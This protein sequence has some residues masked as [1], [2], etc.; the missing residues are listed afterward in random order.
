MVGRKQRPGHGAAGSMRE[1]ENHDTTLHDWT[2]H[3]ISVS[4]GNATMVFRQGDRT[5]SAEL[6]GLD[7]F[8]VRPGTARGTLGLVEHHPLEDGSSLSE[9]SFEFHDDWVVTARAERLRYLDGA[10]A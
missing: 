5:R 2:I 6:V 7:E 1:T 9:F 3:E 4:G 8:S 10:E